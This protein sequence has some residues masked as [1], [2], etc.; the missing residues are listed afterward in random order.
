MVLVA[1]NEELVANVAEKRLDINGMLF[2]S[3]VL[4]VSAVVN[5]DGMSRFVW[6]VLTYVKA[7]GGCQFRSSSALLVAIALQRLVIVSGIIIIAS[8]CVLL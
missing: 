2:G 5:A 8:C 7:T 6:Q 1:G 3:G 4:V